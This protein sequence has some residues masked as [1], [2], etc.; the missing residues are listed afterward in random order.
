MKSDKLPSV[1]LAKNPADSLSMERAL[2]QIQCLL[3]QVEV[4]EGDDSGEDM[5]L[6]SLDDI[7]TMIDSIDRG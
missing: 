3:A 5:L 2:K 4:L 1:L 7:Q 6:A